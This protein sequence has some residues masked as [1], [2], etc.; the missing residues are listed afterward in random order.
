MDKSQGLFEA[1]A[2]SMEAE[3]VGLIV[4]QVLL[5]SRVSDY[6]ARRD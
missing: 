4:S 3:A 6:G 5:N 2:G 1:A